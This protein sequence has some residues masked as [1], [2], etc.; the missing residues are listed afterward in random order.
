MD[1]WIKYNKG[2]MDGVTAFKCE[3]KEHNILLVCDHGIS[4]DGINQIRSYQDD[5][6]RIILDGCFIGSIDRSEKDI[7][8]SAIDECIEYLELKIYNLENDIEEIEETIENME[9]VKNVL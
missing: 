6:Y 3:I 1:N 2:F 5:C 7:F 4:N 8:T 9:V